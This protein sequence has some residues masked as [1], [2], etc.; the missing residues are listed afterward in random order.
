MDVDVKILH[1]GE[2]C[3]DL[4]WI[5]QSQHEQQQQLRRGP[6][7]SPR[8]GRRFHPLS[9]TSASDVG[10]QVHVEHAIYS[11]VSA[12][13]HHAGTATSPLSSPFMP[14]QSLRLVPSENGE[15]D[16]LNP[17]SLESVSAVAVSSQ[18]LAA[19][20]APTYKPDVR[21]RQAPVFHAN[22]VSP[23]PPPPPTQRPGLGPQAAVPALT[24]SNDLQ[25]SSRYESHTMASYLRAQARVSDRAAIYSDLGELPLRQTALARR[26]LSFNTESGLDGLT[27]A[28]A[29]RPTSALG[30]LRE[31]PG[32]HSDNQIHAERPRSSM[33]FVRHR[34]RAN[35][36]VAPS[37][38][39]LSAHPDRIGFRADL[40]TGLDKPEHI[41]S[42]RSLSEHSSEFDAANRAPL[43]EFGPDLARGV[44]VA[45]F[46]EPRLY[47]LTVW[48]SVPAEAMPTPGDQ[49]LPA[50]GL[51]PD[52][53]IHSAGVC[54]DTP[55]AMPTLY[56]WETGNVHLR[57]LPRSVRTTVRVR[58]P[59][60]QMVVHESDAEA[61]GNI[62]LGFADDQP[63]LDSLTE[64]DGSNAPPV[65]P[66]RQVMQVNIADVPSSIYTS[67]PKGSGLMASN[68]SSV[69]G[70]A[71]GGGGGRGHGCFYRV[72]MQQPGHIEPSLV[73]TESARTASTRAPVRATN[74][75]LYP[76]SPS[77]VPLDRS[78]STEGELAGWLNTDDSD[79]AEDGFGDFSPMPPPTAA[80]EPTCGDI[81]TLLDNRLQ[82]FID[83]YGHRDLAND[84]QPLLVDSDGKLDAGDD[85]LGSSRPRSRSELQQAR[86]DSGNATRP[87]W[88]DFAQRQTQV[89]GIDYQRTELT[90]F[91]LPL[92]D[93]I[94]FSWAPRLSEYCQPVVALDKML[95]VEVL[96]TMPLTGEDAIVPVLG[97][98]SLPPSLPLISTSRHALETIFSAESTPV[99]SGR[100]DSF[101]ALT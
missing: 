99:G 52:S 48:F 56:S 71:G 91:K 35:S 80:Y 25:H 77:S 31:I 57:G 41:S 19:R 100:M 55:P 14:R 79:A 45:R 6:D 3:L 94:S 10:S 29:P 15:P 39:G 83:E 82:R 4:L 26:T 89:D 63:C 5:G 87:S 65:T 98:L 85:P 44:F 11:I 69:S 96:P 30:D 20:N 73:R 54:P 50:G 12:P 9:S 18:E 86:M 16:S 58:L 2:Q 68:L 84:E 76:D 42:V 22:A 95:N 32:F 7:E 93:S 75:L 88:T 47:H 66:K 81:E 8:T 64:L 49:K 74:L 38:A 51:T 43:C 72:K 23:Y 33:G 59:H 62:L 40:P 37:T 21:A 61:S 90:V 97:R 1:P 13:E 78:A 34:L 24:G 92:A 70:I 53:A 28:M 27:N 46:Y 60:R 36:E 67:R 17:S 101:A